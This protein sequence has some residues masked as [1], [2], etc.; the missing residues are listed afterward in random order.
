MYA[1][2]QSALLD[3]RPHALDSDVGVGKA[4]KICLNSIF[5]RLKF[6]FRKIA[7]T[8]VD[9]CICDI[10]FYVQTIIISA[11][12][13]LNRIESMICTNSNVARSPMPCADGMIFLCTL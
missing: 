5:R 8:L 7:G 13:S 10:I 9:L 1:D 2:Q 12:P 3:L 4:C 11:T 6:W